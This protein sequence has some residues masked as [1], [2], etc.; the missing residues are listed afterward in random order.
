MV[1]RFARD[2]ARVAAAHDPWRLTVE[3]RK[4]ALP[5]RLQRG[6]DPW[7][8]IF[9]HVG[10]ARRGLDEILRDTKSTCSATAMDGPGPLP[11]G[12]DPSARFCA[13]PAAGTGF[14][15][16]TLDGPNRLGR[17]RAVWRTA[18]GSHQGDPADPD[19]RGPSASKH[20]TRPVQL[21]PRRGTQWRRQSVLI[22]VRPTR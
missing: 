3:Q 22:W 4:T 21:V 6:G 2:V 11:I 1:R 8:A 10:A 13:A 7:Q 9:S 5:G 16:E 15:G 14:S 19:N 17:Y 20:S 18:S 12:R